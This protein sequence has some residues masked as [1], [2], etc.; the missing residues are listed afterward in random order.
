[1]RKSDF[2]RFYDKHIDHVYRFIFFRVNH[3]RDI[4]EDLTSEIFMKVLQNFH[5]Y[6]PK[7]SQTAWVM[8]IARNHLINHY[9]DRKEVIDVDEISFKLEGSDGRED[10]ERLDD[11]ATLQKA[12][13]ELDAKDRQLIELKY[14]QGYRYKEIA[15]IIGKSAGAVRVEAHRAMKKLKAKLEGKYEGRQNTTGEAAA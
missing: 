4:A 10:I 2:T 3:N 7:R 9:R 1:M 11:Q 12:M 5:S 14:L 6:D 15:G 13:S 8:T